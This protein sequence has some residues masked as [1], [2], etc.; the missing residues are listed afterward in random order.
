MAEADHG[1]PPE[2][3]VRVRNRILA[4]GALGLL[5]I[6]VVAGVIAAVVNFPRGV[7]VIAAVVGALVGAWRGVLHRGAERAALL[8]LALALIVVAIVLLVGRDLLL[9]LLVVIPAAGAVI[10]AR[11]AVIS[12]A[13]L[14]PADPP[15]RAV[16]IFNPRSGGGKAIQHDLAAQARKRGIEPFEMNFEVGLEQ[17]VHDL[18]DAG[19]DGLAVAGGDGSQAT[20]AAIAAR[21]DVPYACIPAGTRN[22]FALDLGVDRE[23]VV[24]ALDAFVKGGERI[25]DLAEVNGQVFVN[26]VSLGVYG[27]AV[28]ESGYRAAKLRTLLGVLSDEAGEAGR[29]GRSP[30][31][32]W[33]DADGVTHDGGLT[34]LVSNNPYRL[35]RLVAAGTRPRLDAGRLGVAVIEAGGRLGRGSLRRWSPPAIEVDGD[36]PI[37]AGVDGEAVMLSTPVRFGI[38]PHALRVR[39]APQHPGCSPS[40]GLPTGVWAGTQ[41]LARLAVSGTW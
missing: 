11:A 16:L 21:R 6:T 17:M 29:T 36:G 22:H 1:A 4:A 41:A 18:L 38:R 20:V 19:A 26:N 12:R 2:L 27:Q 10:C 15:A 31:P 8:A 24:G 9:T 7:F 40:A 34:L 5:T 37:P 25:V 39:I 28:Q 30:A 23:D 33:R 3:Q 13:R 35:G 32:R 14:A